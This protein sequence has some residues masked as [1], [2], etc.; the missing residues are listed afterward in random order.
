VRT[1]IRQLGLDPEQC[2]YEMPG[3]NHF[4][5]LTRLS[6][7]GQDALPL[8]DRWIETEAPRYWKTCRFSDYLGPVPVDIYKRFGVFPIGDTA[9]PGGGSWPWWY[10]TDYWTERRWREAPFAWY[11]AY[12]RSLKRNV[13][14][15]Q[16]ADPAAIFGTD[17]SGEQS[18]PLIQ[19]IVCDLPRT[20]IVNIPN[21]GRFV[22]GLPDDF[23]VEVPARVDKHGIQGQRTA[24][25]PR[26]ILSHVWRDR[27]APVEMELAAFEQGRKSLLRQLVMLDPWTR[28]VR[29]ADAFLD[30]ILALPY[31]EEMR[32]HYQ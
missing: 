16:I 23:A 5:F 24:G 7:R 28:S 2:E 12:F 15:S 32:Q 25:L 30:A 8:L 27:V 9:N 17:K 3:V 19:S 26:A 20:Y 18:I 29:Q 10:H 22:P 1:L 6:H 13:R 11:A 31:H 14:L 4:I 21:L